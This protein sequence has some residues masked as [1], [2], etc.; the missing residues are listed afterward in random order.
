MQG[1]GT[2]S[3][4]SE[5][6]KIYIHRNEYAN[7]APIADGMQAII[8]VDIMMKDVVDTTDKSI[9]S[10]IEGRE[11]TVDK[12]N[13]TSTSPPSLNQAYLQS[14]SVP[15]PLPVYSTGVTKLM[16]IDNQYKWAI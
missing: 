5:S 4:V 9:K 1:Q 10:M 14:S 8:V 15:A 7:K 6:K 16:Q 3:G 13:I 12:L 11:C 2:S